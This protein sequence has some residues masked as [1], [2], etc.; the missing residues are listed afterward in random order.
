MTLD[1]VRL[2]LKQQERRE[3]AYR[4]AMGMLYF[5]GVTIAPKE[6]YIPRGTTL[7]ILSGEAYR[8]STGAEAEAL[9]EALKEHEQELTPEERRILKMREK[10]MRELRVIPEEEYTAYQTLLNEAAVVW[11]EAKERSDFEHFRPVLEKLVAANRRFAELAAPDKEPYDYCLDQYEEGLTMERCD[12]FFAAVRERLMPLL[13][14]VKN[15]KAPSTDVLNVHFP[16]AAQEQFSDRLMEIL[17]MDKNRSLI[18]TTEHPFTTDFSKY[19]VRITTKYHED[20]FSASMF[21][22]IHEGGHALYELHTAD[23]YAYTSL[24]SGVS[25]GIHESQSR[26]FENIIGRS[27]AFTA[28]LWDEITPLCPELNKYT[29]EDFYRAVNRAEPSLI[30]IY[31]DEV[32]YCLHIML[33]YEAEKALISG[34]VPVSEAPALWNSLVREYLG[35]EVPDD[36]HGILQDSHWSGGSFGYFPSY[37]LG[38]AYGAQLLAK[39]RE[40]VDVDSA[41]AKDLAPVRDWLEERI[42][43]YGA[44]YAPAELLERACGES[45][46]PNYFLD[47]LE[48]KMADVYEL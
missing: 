14:K 24:G 44:L 13:E 5:D 8:M 40:T 47:Y 39:M 2:A 21:S 36:A 23:E 38:S 31:A 3:F 15:A 35:L 30:R 19:D 34:K 6:S 25:M 20:N 33:R 1:E 29:A 11:R 9:I 4:H 43:R 7:E 16:R 41:A 10:S 27:R 26:F 18:G 32:T 22:V 12:A 42:W 48:A 45:F 17:G 46:N 37:A 28:R